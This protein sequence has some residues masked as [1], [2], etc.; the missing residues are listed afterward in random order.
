MGVGPTL[1]ELSLIWRQNKEGVG[2][3]GVLSCIILK[4]KNLFFQV[5]KF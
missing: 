4:N 1:G 3:E 2:M 5:S